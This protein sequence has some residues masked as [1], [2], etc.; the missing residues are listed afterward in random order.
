MVIRA[1]AGGVA[2]VIL[3]LAGVSRSTFRLSP[4]RQVMVPCDAQLRPGCCSE[5]AF[6]GE[7]IKGN[8]GY[9]L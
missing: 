1:G 2:C 6:A 9:S 5:R 4:C 3:G 8:G 7:D